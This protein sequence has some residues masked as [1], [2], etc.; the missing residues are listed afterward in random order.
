MN[1][2]EV[3]TP[4]FPCT[5]CGDKKVD[6]EGAYSCRWGCEPWREYKDQMDVYKNR[7]KK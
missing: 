4:S 1:K 7:F 3:V 6:G 2:V 5:K